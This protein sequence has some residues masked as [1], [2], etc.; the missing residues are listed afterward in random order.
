MPTSY[1]LRRAGVNGALPGRWSENDLTVVHAGPGDFWRSPFADAGDDELVTTY[2]PLGTRRVV[3]GHI[4]WP[5]IRRLPSF[6]LANSGSVSLS[7]DG[8]R[9]AAYALVDDNQVTIRRVE[10]DV[11]REAAT[12]LARQYPD[13]AW[14]ATWL[15]KG[16]ANQRSAVRAT[17]RRGCRRRRAKAPALRQPSDGKSNLAPHRA[18]I[19][20]RGRVV[21]RRVR[22]WVVSATFSARR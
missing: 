15:R 2:G 6:T 14:L 1:W 10:Y 11:E 22:A 16:A 9:R 17:A 12:L 4:H 18:V 5:Y 20:D 13:A 21:Q 8:D 3:Y 19:M 7:Y